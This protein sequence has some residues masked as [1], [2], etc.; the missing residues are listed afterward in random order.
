MR[1]VDKILTCLNLGDSIESNLSSFMMEMK[2]TAF[3]L[4]SLSSHSLVL[5]NE[6][7]RGTSDM[8]ALAI[9]WSCCERLRV[10]SWLVD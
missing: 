6:L 2:E 8:E 3:V 4:N 5:F 9:S 7:G 1:L 10:C